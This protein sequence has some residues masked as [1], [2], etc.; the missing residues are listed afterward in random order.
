[1]ND[2]LVTLDHFRS[3]LGVDGENYFVGLRHGSM[4]CEL[5]KPVG[6]DGQT[7]HTQDELYIVLQGSGTFFKAGERKLFNPGDVIFVEAGVE[8][9]FE[10]FTA[11]FETWVVFWGAEGG[12]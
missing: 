8:H 6:S 4:R 11:D 5:Y 7:A 2:W 12:E 3:Q 1:M 9:R 10:D